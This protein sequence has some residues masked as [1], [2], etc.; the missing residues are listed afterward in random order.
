[1]MEFSYL[2]II[3]DCRKNG[4]KSEAAK[5]YFFLFPCKATKFDMRDKKNWKKPEWR[6]RI[7]HVFC[8]V[9]LMK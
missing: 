1:M 7:K 9:N 4:K 3:K 5:D 8:N 2:L 6:I